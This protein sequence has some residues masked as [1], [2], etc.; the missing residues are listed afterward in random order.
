[1]RPQPSLHEVTTNSPQKIDLR[2]GGWVAWMLAQ[3][4]RP[5]YGVIGGLLIAMRMV[6]FEPK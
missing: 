1:M 6:R 4:R 3:K 2:R 5:I